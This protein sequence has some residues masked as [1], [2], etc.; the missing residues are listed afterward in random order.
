MKFFIDNIITH[1]NCRKLDTIDYL[2]TD[3]EKSKNSDA[4]SDTNSNFSSYKDTNSNS[5][6]KEELK[7][8]YEEMIEILENGELSDYQKLM[9]EKPVL[10]SK[11][12]REYFVNGNQLNDEKDIDKINE[13][14]I[15]NYG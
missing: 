10:L 14:T 15:K 2:N 11:L 8:Q 1:E 3:S 7:E 12:L 13:E 9:E 5:L 4:K 6:Y